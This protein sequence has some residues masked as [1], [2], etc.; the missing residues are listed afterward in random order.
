M[1][2]QDE[3]TSIVMEMSSG[4]HGRVDQLFKLAYDDLRGVADKY[5]GRFSAGD[6][7][8]PTELVHEAYLRLVDHTQVDWRGKSHFLAVGAIA[9]RQILVDLARS[10]QT[11]KRGGG[12]RRVPLD[13]IGK[14]SVTS[15][16][17]ILAVDE[18]LQGL[19]AISETQAKLVEL[20]FFGGMTFPEVAE[21]L[22]MSQRNAEKQWTFAKTW[23]RRELSEVGGDE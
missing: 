6:P 14:I 16:D 20:R 9:M 10:K 4:D 5:A 1:T 7:L 12:Y 13:E 17:D 18:A 22:G 8:R 2:T 3:S 15:A 21:A 23:L 11:Q 19:A